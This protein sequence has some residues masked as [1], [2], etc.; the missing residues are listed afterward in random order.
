MKKLIPLLILFSACTKEDIIVPQKNYTFSIDSVLTETGTK[1]LAIDVNGF[2]HLKLDTTKNQSPHRITGKILVNGNEPKPAEKIEWE[3]NLNWTLKKGDTIAY[4]TK[5][6]INY[7]TGKFTI[8]SLP[9]F[10]SSVTEL[11]PTINPASYSGT[12]GQ[13][14]IMIAPISKMKGDTMIVKGFNYNSNKTIYT[15]IVLE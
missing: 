7:Y 1:S 6:Y 15:K 2:Y 3:S 4:I 14:N 5:S 11:V 10:V 9:P 12:N 8:V 13:I